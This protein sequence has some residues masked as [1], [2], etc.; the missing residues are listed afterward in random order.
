MSFYARSSV[1]STIKYSKSEE[2][3]AST[4][5]SFSVPVSWFLSFC[6]PPG[7]CGQNWQGP[8]KAVKNSWG[9]MTF[10]SFLYLG[11]GS[12]WHLTFLVANILVSRTCLIATSKS[13]TRTVQDS[14]LSNLEAIRW[15]KFCKYKFIS[16]FFPSALSLSFS[17][18]LGLDVSHWLKMSW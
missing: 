13:S 8:G 15:K 6:L 7:I 18:W 2:A 11:R 10:R 16:I 3:K 5:G 4:D 1:T 12:Y 9:I 14:L 17:V